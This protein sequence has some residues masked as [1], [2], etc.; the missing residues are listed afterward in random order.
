MG[1]LD[2]FGTSMDDP[3]T[4]ATLQLAQ[5]LLSSPRVMQG[6]AGGL[7]GYQQAM[8]QAK[9]AKAVEEM[10][11]M[12]LQQ[13]QMQ[14]AAQ[15][16]Q[17]EQAQLDREGMR[18]LSMPIAGTEANKASG[19]MGP[20]PQAAAVIGK[21]PPLD[22]ASM[23]AKGMSPQAIEQMFAVRN[24]GVKQPMKLGAGE[25]VFS[26]DGRM[27]F[28]N[29]KEDT[30]PTAVREFQFALQNPEF[31]AY[32]ERLKRAGSTKVQVDAGQ[33]FENEFSKDQGK[34]FSEMKGNI[35]KA[36]FSA[37]SQIRKLERMQELLDGVD[38][39][40]LS[41]VGL[42]VASALNSL[43]IKVDPKLGNKEASEALARDLAG[44]LRQP[45]TGPMTDKDFDN[46]MLQVPS[47]SKTAEGRRQIIETQKR[48]LNRDI[49]VA[50]MA[51]EYQNKNGVLDDGFM[52]QVSQ[53]IAETPV[54][55][56]PSGWK[57]KR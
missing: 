37:P 23:L 34:F 44:G 48:A 18:Q 33:R 3:R 35:V 22:P 4:A 29:P 16:Q 8:A 10:R 52:E 49:Q 6:L 25:A 15:R 11:Q 30:T 50:K 26:P 13:M 24:I 53:Y 36:G 7:S 54:V 47:L 39:G 38:G 41:P 17:Q 46:F 45:G 20:T 42:E 2:M 32:Q 1:L 51:R 28:G 5:G 55:A 31:A 21:L 14:M 12:Q 27:L 19:L 40:K 9:Q 56:P 43:G 57:V